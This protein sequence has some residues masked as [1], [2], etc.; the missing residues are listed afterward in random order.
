MALVLSACRTA[1]DLNPDDPEL[2]SFT[3]EGNRAYGAQELE[4]GLATETGTGWPWSNKSRFDAAIFQGDVERLL[5][6]YRAHGY[7]DVRLVALDVRP[8]PSG[9]VDVRVQLEEGLPFKIRSLRVDG[10]ELLPE[11]LQGA[12]ARPLPSRVG[13][14]FNQDAY[15]QTK[16][17][18]AERLREF[19]YAGAVVQGRADVDGS[20]RAVDVVFTLQAGPHY[21]YGTFN[22]T[23]NHVVSEARIRRD[24]QSVLKAGGD[25]KAADLERARSVL[26]QA[27]VFANVQLGAGASDPDAGTLG[28]DVSV[29][30][31]PFHTLRAGVGLGSDVAKQEIH[32]SSGYTDRN[33]LGNLRRLD[34][35]AAFAVEW[36]PNVFR[37]QFGAAQ[38]AFKSSV[39]LTQ[40]EF[41]GRQIDLETSLQGEREVEIGYGDWAAHARVAVPWRA[42]P[43]LTLTASYNVELTFFD[44]GSGFNGLSLSPASL[45][46]LG[47]PNHTGPYVLSYLEQSVVWDRRDSAVTPTSGTLARLAL[48]EAGGPLFGTFSNV[49]ASA[50]AR[51]YLPLGTRDVL[52]VRLQ[53]GALLPYAGTSSPI[54][55]R[56]FLGG[57]DSVR[58]YGSLRL[59]PAARVNTCGPSINGG[60]LCDTAANSIGVIDVP[61]GGNGMFEASAELRH[62]LSKTFAAV[63]FADTGAVTQTAFG[64]DFGAS[65]L[66]FSPGLG[67]RIRTP[68]GPIRIDL[69][70]LLVSPAREVNVVT[71]T[72]G[73]QPTGNYPVPST[74]AGAV[75]P[76]GW[77]FVP[78]SG[79]SGPAAVG[80][81]V[82][83]YAQPSTCRSEAL[84]RLALSVAIG[85]AF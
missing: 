64:P 44:L 85:E 2:A 26:L 15:R 9:A 24:L 57:L 65:R 72:F 27:G 29:L 8:R 84:R 68:I 14:L 3:L 67:L 30:E 80:G 62:S 4:A 74:T 21:R 5:T 58:G 34:F 10:A 54:D 31:A 52:A 37:P 20:A 61:V 40:P 42:T 6:F 49:R 78:Q 35:D 1:P 7:F 22:I 77:P 47:D 45:L 46:Q 71:Q 12:L 81:A 59:S 41:F 63:A 51:G 23:G 69:A 17:V 70:Y 25:F 75:D 73:V 28:V 39:K 48:Q 66:A 76:C 38:P 18:L 82:L 33:F 50:E 19:A 83:P 55:Q 36:L 53:A 56:F 43:T 13:D 79:W 16:F 32:V 11:G 60:S